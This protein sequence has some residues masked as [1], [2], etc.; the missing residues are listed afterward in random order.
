MRW[1]GRYCVFIDRIPAIKLPLSVLVFDK[2]ICCITLV[3][4]VNNVGCR[5]AQ[6]PKGELNCGKWY[7]G[8]LNISI[9]WMHF[10]T[11]F[12]TL[13]EHLNIFSTF[14]TSDVQQCVCICDTVLIH[15][16]VI[17]WKGVQLALFLE[18]DECVKWS[19][20][21]L[22]DMSVLYFWG[23]RGSCAECHFL[24]SLVYQLCLALW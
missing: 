4:G 5:Y 14:F 10:I 23:V 3:A 2:I 8:I 22:Y 16:C 7:I 6:W 24:F 20:M 1:H 13:F 19:N 15:C 17:C 11:L 18:C 9:K 12:A 21:T